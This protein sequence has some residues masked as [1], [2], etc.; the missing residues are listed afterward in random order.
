MLFLWALVLYVAY[1]FLKPL[2]SPLKSVPG[3]LLARY[4]R[5]WYLKKVYDGNFEKV[6]IELHERYG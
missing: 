2:W 3:P 4:T 5:L 6:N 1:F